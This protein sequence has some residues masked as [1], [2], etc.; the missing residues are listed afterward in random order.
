MIFVENNRYF[1]RGMVSTVLVKSTGDC[2]ASEYAIF[3]DIAQYLPWIT[4]VTNEPA[5]TTDGAQYLPPITNG[6]ANTTDDD[7][8]FVLPP[9]TEMPNACVKKVQCD[10]AYK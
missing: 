5:K 7:T 8:Q 2:I 4:E 3:T 1:I 9:I 10:R 6:A